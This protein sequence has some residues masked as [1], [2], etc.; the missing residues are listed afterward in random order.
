MRDRIC[1]IIMQTCVQLWVHI[2]KVVLVRDHVHMFLSILPK[3]SLSDVMQFIKGRSS[4]RIQ[5]GFPQLHKR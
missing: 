1:K 4:R 3:V 2:A 5:I